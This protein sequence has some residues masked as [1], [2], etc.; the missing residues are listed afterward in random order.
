[1]TPRHGKPLIAVTT[2]PRDAG[3]VKG[4]DTTTA[5][6]MQM[7]YVEAIWRAGCNEAMVAPRH[8]SHED[9]LDLLT[10]VDGLV[11]V[12][13]GDIDPARYADQRHPEVYDVYESSDAL[14]ITLAQA[15][16]ELGVP[17]LAICRGMQVLN[18]ALGGTLRQHLEPDD[19]WQPHRIG[20]CHS[21]EVIEGS[22]LSECGHR[23][24]AA[25]SFHHQAIDTLGDQLVVTAKADDGCIEAI[26]LS[27]A[28]TWIVGV[29]WHP[30]RTAATDPQQQW[31][32]DTLADHARA[33]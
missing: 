4:W 25:W 12:G 2:R 24:D 7:L 26:E 13:G 9:A 23:F 5:A 15:A 14:E 11:L 20:E 19:G 1:M 17:T 21:V 18:V 33:R 27:A 10:R 22:R 16:V 28:D 32:F 8:L 30:E 6:V 3:G 29:Q 31:L